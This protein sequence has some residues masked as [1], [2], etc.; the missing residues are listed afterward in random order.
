[1][2]TEDDHKQESHV[3]I[4]FVPQTPACPLTSRGWP[5]VG[6]QGQDEHKRKGEAMAG[7]V[8]SL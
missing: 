2:V 5:H 1:M 7:A 4:A 3:I 6:R 8:G